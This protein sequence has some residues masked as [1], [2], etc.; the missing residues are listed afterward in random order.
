MAINTAIIPYAQGI[1]FAIPINSARNCTVGMI[2]GGVSARPWLGIVGLSVTGE[3]ARYYS[4]PLE[5]G[6][7]VTKVVGASP[8]ERAGIVAGDMILRLD[9]GDIYSIED[10]LSE[11]HNR[12]IG[13]KVRI[14]VYRR[15]REENLETPLTKTP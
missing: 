11:I 5:R 12:K 4:L 14:T 2:E 1:G 15:G 3:L 9:G 7:L 6:V 8:A 10:L 13:D